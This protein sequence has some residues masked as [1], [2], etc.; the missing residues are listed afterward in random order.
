MGTPMSMFGPTARGREHSNASSVPSSAA[1]SRAA[2]KQPPPL[3]DQLLSRLPPTS[4]AERKRRAANVRIQAWV[5][6]WREQQLFARRREVFAVV[7]GSTTLERADGTPTAI[8]VYL[9]T[10][11]RGGRCWQA[12]ALPHGDLISTRVT[13]PSAI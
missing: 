10:V 4:D 11:M 13:P 7:S 6:R 2:P 12:A 3:W 9:V 8:P 1:S 5:R